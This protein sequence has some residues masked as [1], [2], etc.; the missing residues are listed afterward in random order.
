[1]DILKRRGG[2]I[3]VEGEKEDLINICEQNFEFDYESR[4]ILSKVSLE[5]YENATYGNVNTYVYKTANDETVQVR[6][7]KPGRWCLF[8][9]ESVI[10]DVI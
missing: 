5:H 8:A 7:F 1:M 3:F 2:Y 6:K 4:Q 10:G 9:K